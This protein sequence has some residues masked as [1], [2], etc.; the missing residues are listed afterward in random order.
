M[1]A[2]SGV[3]RIIHHSTSILEQLMFTSEQKY[4]FNLSAE[5]RTQRWPAERPIQASLKNGLSKNLVP[6]IFVLYR[7]ERG[8]PHSKISIG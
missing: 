7:E 5:E 4:L 2:F 6:S 3:G 8:K 1:T